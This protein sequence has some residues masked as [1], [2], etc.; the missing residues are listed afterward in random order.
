MLCISHKITQDLQFY[1]QKPQTRMLLFFFIFSRISSLFFR[2]VL[3]QS[4]DVDYDFSSSLIFF[5]VFSVF[6]FIVL[7]DFLHR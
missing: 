1:T 6:G 3:S 2:K 7:D 4:L 5:I